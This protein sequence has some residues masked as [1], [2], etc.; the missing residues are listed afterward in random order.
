MATATAIRNITGIGPAYASEPIRPLTIPQTRRES[1][2][3][4]SAALGYAYWTA[5]NIYISMTGEV[6]T[7]DLDIYVNGKQVVTLKDLRSD[8][9]RYS[10]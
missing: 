4:K 6:R 3:V 5:E 9:T 2:R 8:G 1:T 10:W 7:A